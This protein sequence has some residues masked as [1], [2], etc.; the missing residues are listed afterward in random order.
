[1]TLLSPDMFVKPVEGHDDLVAFTFGFGLAPEGKAVPDSI[2][3]APESITELEDGDLLI[4]GW[5][6]N[7]IGDDREG[8]NFT[9]GAFQRGIKAFLD[10]Q[11]ALCYHHQ[12]DKGIGRVTDLQEVEGKGL[13]ME[14]RVDHQP[15]SSPLRYIY[16]AIKKGTYR[17]LS[18]GGIFKRKVIDGARKIADVDFA[19]ISVT[20]VP[21]HP[22]TGFGVVAGKAL[23]SMVEEP[24]A[25]EVAEVSDEQLVEIN[26]AVERLR[27]VVE[28]IESKALPK[29]H[30][31]QGSMVLS[32]FL[33]TIGQAR[34]FAGAAASIS[35]NQELVDLGNEVESTAVKWEAAAHKLAAKIGPLPPPVTL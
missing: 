23:E 15:E 20:P 17:G 2:Q 26:S 22:G 6:A 25:E 21:V 18:I 31:P 5:A 28:Q 9:D 12:T 14:A 1:M 16:N 11:A 10:G 32:E 24:P 27:N 13:Y 34:S 8:E 3:I 7:F 33:A 4:K 35:E 19:E 29:S 30:D